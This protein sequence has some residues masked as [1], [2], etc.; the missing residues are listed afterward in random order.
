MADYLDNIT[1][2]AV[3]S[4][5]NRASDPNSLLYIN[6]VT[7]M[8]IFSKLRT[9]SMVDSCVSELSGLSD[10]PHFSI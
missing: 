6:I 9:T 5:L 2:S 4:R 1:V 8:Q 3:H 7:S 10:L